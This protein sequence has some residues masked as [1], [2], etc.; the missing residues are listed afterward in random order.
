M[1]ARSATAE[2]IISAAETRIR[3]A[4]YHAVSF[5]DL[6][7]DVGVKSASV[8][9]HFPTKEDLGTAVASDYARRFMEALG[10]PRDPRI[11][12][13]SLLRRY[14]EAY[15]RALTEDGQMCLCGVLASEAE[16]LPP[17]VRAAATAFFQANLNW[18]QQVVARRHPGA[19][20]QQIADE[21]ATILSLTQG[22]MLV[23]NALDSDA[24][25]ERAVRWLEVAA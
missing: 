6:A 1:P 7:A 21:A 17:G 2:K 9:H 24:H 4:G 10:D 18:L 22:A 16:G 13:N 8:H 15:R 12:A 14:V 20:S 5:R 23:A 19:S 25:F 11:D 3:D